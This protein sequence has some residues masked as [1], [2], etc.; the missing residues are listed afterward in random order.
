MDIK[1]PLMVI[2]TAERHVLIYNLNNPS[3]P[4]KTLQSSL[5]FQSRV[6]TCFPDTTG[7]ALGSIE[8]RVAIEYVE[9]SDQ[10]KKFS[11]FQFN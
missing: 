11:Y 5:K 4:Y 2:A 8:G 10:S 9:D 7:Y 6:V 3:A 1:G